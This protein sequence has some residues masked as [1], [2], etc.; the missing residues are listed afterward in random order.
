MDLIIND[1]YDS[2]RDLDNIHR[3]LRQAN[4]C[5]LTTEVVWSALIVMRNNP[6]ITILQAME[7]AYHEWIK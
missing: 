3:I 2:E 5:N 1:D 4:S 7:T 6:D